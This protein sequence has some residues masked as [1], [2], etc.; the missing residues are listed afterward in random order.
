MRRIKIAPSILSADPAR[1]GE[2]LSVLD[3]CKDVDLL[4]IDIMD[5]HFVPN[6]T[7]GPH[8]VRAMRKYTKK[9]FYVHLMLTNPSIFIKPFAEAGANLISVHVECMENLSTLFEK[10]KAAGVKAG[11]ALNP[12]TPAH[13]VEPYIQN[14]EEIVVMS[15]Y[16]GFGG[17]KFI[18]SVLPKINEIRKIVEKSKR[19]IDIAVDGGINASTAPPAVRNGANL[20]ISGN[21]IF[22]EGHPDTTRI[23]ELRKSVEGPR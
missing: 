7:F 6:L 8:V 13:V 10:I 1:M 12:N 19:E 14:V 2:V 23:R 5:G 3:D 22:V 17:Q 11:I 18:E 9:E 20:L 4:H 16:P 15:V 21:G